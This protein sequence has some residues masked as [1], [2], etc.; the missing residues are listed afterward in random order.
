MRFWRKKKE[1]V[2]CIETWK[3]YKSVEEAAEDNNVSIEELK[4]CLDGKQEICAGKHWIY[5][6]VEFMI[7]LL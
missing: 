5:C 2:R 6:S 7:C 4:A 3:R 1:P